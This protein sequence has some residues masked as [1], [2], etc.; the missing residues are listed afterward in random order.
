MSC[1]LVGPCAG[2]GSLESW[3]A[4]I[5]LTKVLEGTIDGRSI[6]GLKRAVQRKMDRSTPT[7]EGH[8]MNAFY[9]LV[10]AAASLSPSNFHSTSQSDQDKTL[11]LM[12][13]NNVDLPSNLKY[14]LLMKKVNSQ[15]QQCN[16]FDL[17][18]TVS[19][20]IEVCWCNANQTLGGLEQNMRIAAWR[21]LLFE[22]TLCPLLTQGEAG[23]Q[24]VGE[25]SIQ[26]QDQLQCVDVVELDL[27]TASALEEGNTVFKAIHDLLHPSLENP[28]ED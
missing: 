9:K 5:S 19:P 4:K 15:I 1:V 14:T 7:A 6:Q 24:K 16:Y 17:V 23:A 3:K 11:M 18:T 26:C 22:D 12:E 25:L 8:A 13:E 10:L 21:K 28:F 2:D 20:F 27:I